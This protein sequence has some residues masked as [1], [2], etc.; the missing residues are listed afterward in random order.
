MIG[1]L[2]TRAIKAWNKA[3]STGLLHIFGTSVINKIIGFCSSIVLVR[4]VSKAEYGIYTYAE[5][6]LS[7]F[8]LATGLGVTSGILQL[9]SETK[10]FTHKRNIYQYGCRIGVFTNAILA[11]LILIVAVLVPLPIAGSNELLGM[12]CL[13][14]LASLL[15]ELQRTYLRTELRNKEFS[16]ANS[17]NTVLVFLLSCFFAYLYR[18]RGL[19]VAHYLAAVFTFLFIIFA[20]HTPFGLKSEGVSKEEKQLM[21]NISIISM[22]NNG[23]SR[24][25]YLLDIFALG[26]FIKNDSVIA[27]YKIATIIPTALLFIPSSI[28]MYAYPLFAMNRENKEWVKT[29][30]QKITLY[31]LLL[32]FSISFL[33]F[34]FAPLIITIVFREQYLDA[35]IPFR[36]LSI[37]FAFSST[38]RIIAGNILVT[39]RKLRFNLIIAVFSSLFNTVL[40]ILL[41]REWKSVGA[42]I[43][44]LLTVVATSIINVWYLSHTIN[45][46]KPIID[47][48]S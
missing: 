17:F 29:R 37:S 19:V 43:A 8:T 7:F 6:I 46:I 16:Y 33:L 21:L 39:Q 24:L 36:I 13:L 9:C 32:N 5:N 28:M 18:A 35:L 22:M 2:Q 41:I 11:T 10:D 3:F 27:S 1:N 4:I 26:I 45:R 34:T 44:T 47:K 14:P 42:A 25:M 40:N 20:F 31:S 38:F 15:S 12:M 48:E 23:L 30:Y